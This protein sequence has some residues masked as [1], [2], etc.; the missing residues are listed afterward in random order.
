GGMIAVQ[1]PTLQEIVI[2]P[3]TSSTQL[4][5][6]VVHAL[7]G[8]DEEGRIAYID[9]YFFVK[10]NK[11]RRHLLK[12]IRVDGQNDTEIFSRPGSAMWA[13]TA[14]GRGEIGQH[15]ALAPVGGRVAFLSGTTNVQMPSGLRTV[16][17]LEIW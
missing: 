15:L 9:D 2:R 1:L 11:D 16:G 7:S 10:N 5:F 6:P 12:T 14:A 17:L 8:P 13:T 3:T 4:G